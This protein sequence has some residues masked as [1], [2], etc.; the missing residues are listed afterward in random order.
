M[1]REHLFTKEQAESKQEILEVVRKRVEECPQIET[2]R[3]YGSWL[4]QEDS[5]DLDVAVIVHSDKGIV[6]P[7]SY[8]VLRA[9]RSD[10]S[11]STKQDIDLV[12]HTDD[13]I[14]DLRSPLFHPRYNPSLLSGYDV[15]GA[16]LVKPSYDLHAS[17]SFADVAA[18][19]LHDNRTICRRQLVRSLQAEEARIYASKL[20]H[21]PGNALTYYACSRGIPYIES[22]S[23]QDV[24][25]EQCDRVFGLQSGPAKAFL[26]SCKNGELSFDDAK[27]LMCWYEH[28]M[29]AVLVGD[30]NTSLYN[31]YCEEISR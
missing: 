10:I 25:L 30:V 12:P 27:K 23:N 22:P 11:L 1:N 31:L 16:F 9:L 6:P 24:A 26:A 3:A 21:G 29:N 2:A 13:E 15:K 5:S 14:G 28:L 4:F 20:L 18:Y 19:T 7:E 8:D 17:F